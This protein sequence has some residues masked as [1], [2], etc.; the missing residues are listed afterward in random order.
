MLHSKFNQ[1]MSK[2]NIEDLEP[3]RRKCG[4]SDFTEYPEQI[5]YQTWISYCCHRLNTTCDIFVLS[6]LASL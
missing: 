5:F 6:D 4:T 3:K 2:S 1:T